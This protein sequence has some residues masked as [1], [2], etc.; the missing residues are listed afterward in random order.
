MHAAPLKSVHLGTV[1]L[2]ASVKTTRNRTPIN[3]VEKTQTL[4]VVTSKEEKVFLDE[5]QTRLFTP[6]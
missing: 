3:S 5:I 2:H 6:T 1:D 4:S